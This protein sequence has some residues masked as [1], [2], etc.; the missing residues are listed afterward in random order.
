[1]IF[2]LNMLTI[3][4]AFKKR[5][6]AYSSLGSGFTYFSLRPI[7]EFLVNFMGFD[8]KGAQKLYVT[9]VAGC[10]CILPYLVE[11]VLEFLTCSI[12]M[13]NEQGDVYDI[14]KWI[15]A[16]GA[17]SGQNHVNI[18]LGRTEVQNECTFLV[19]EVKKC[20]AA[21]STYFWFD[22]YLLHFE[23]TDKQPDDTNLRMLRLREGYLLSSR[24]PFPRF[25]RN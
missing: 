25:P 10:Q 20:S 4:M 6:G 7:F 13:S 15:T 19:L 21:R 11:H 16:H 5:I 14:C 1:M 3:Y 22:R 23:R 8:T 17:G 2:S 9:L 24:L 12:V 18:Q